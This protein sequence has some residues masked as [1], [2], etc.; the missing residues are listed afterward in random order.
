MPTSRASSRPRDGT[1]ISYVSCFGRRVL[2]HQ[3]HLEDLI[4]H[5][6]FSF[7]SGRLPCPSAAGGHP[8]A[9]GVFNWQVYFLAALCSELNKEEEWFWIPHL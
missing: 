5:M 6:L 4:R 8:G 9:E 3:R 2:Y 7:P 1:H